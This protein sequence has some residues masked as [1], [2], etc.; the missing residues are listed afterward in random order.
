VASH[1]LE[2]VP[3]ILSMAEAMA[4][5]ARV[6]HRVPTARTQPHDPPYLAVLEGP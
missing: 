5:E 3:A 4:A 2:I 6:Y 1:F